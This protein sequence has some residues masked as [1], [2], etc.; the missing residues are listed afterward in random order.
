MTQPP[1]RLS[2]LLFWGLWHVV[3]LVLRLYCRF[4][5]EGE[6]P[7]GAVV[8]VANHASFVDPIVLGAAL[9]RRVVFL[10]TEVVYRSRAMGWFYRW[11]CAIPLSTRM[12]N[13]ESMRAARTVLQQERS[14]GIFPEG[15]ISRDGKPLLGNPGAVSLVLNEGVPIVPVGIVGTYDVLP[16]GVALPRPRRLVVRIGAPITP[17]EL[18][19]VGGGRR[20][21]LQ[22]ATR[23][24]MQRIADLTGHEAREAVL[25]T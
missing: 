1:G 16:P 23:L 3:R 12:P 5:V 14:I 4:R 22:N 18:D 10:M 9:P 11:N 25:S 2:N 19:A 20:E 17:A 8:V 6:L 13:R 21:K 15:G 7:A 24:I